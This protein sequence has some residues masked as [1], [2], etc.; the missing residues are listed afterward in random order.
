MIYTVS[1][2][3]SASSIFDGFATIG[4]GASV[5]QNTL[6]LLGC[7]RHQPFEYVLY[8][9]TAAK[10][11]A[12][13]CDGV[14]KSTALVVTRKP[15]SPDD[16]FFKLIQPDQQDKLR[17]QWETYSKLRI[18][19]QSLPTLCQIAQEVMG[20]VSPHPTFKL[21]AESLSPSKSSE[22]KKID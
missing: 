3:G 6:M 19:P 15:K 2:D 14:G 16:D 8:A 13:S 12:E 9:V 10:F 21:I 17:A 11:A 4:S 22:E 1:P 5:A 20:S 7:A 18:P